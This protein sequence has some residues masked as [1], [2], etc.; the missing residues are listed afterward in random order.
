MTLPL[1]A[2]NYWVALGAVLLLCGALYLLVE[3]FF[4]AEKSV[5]PFLRRWGWHAAFA[6][7]LA[8]A[9]GSLMY[10]ETFGFVPCGLCWVQRGFVYSLIVLTALALWKQGCGTLHPS[11]ADY[12]LGLSLTGAAIALYGHLV[13]MGKAALVVCP[14]AGVG[15]DCARRLV[16]EFG[17]VT[18]PLM[19][20]AV[21][22]LVSA[23]FLVWR[24]ASQDT[25][26]AVA[27]A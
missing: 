22:A 18:L 8:A 11:A 12:G 23:V 13:Q 7:A 27:R 20:F 16:F 1:D 14:E 26:Y 6:V 3:H 19:S 9:V 24:T 5:A 15:A 4:L 21:F 17:F 25:R 2:Y 10:S